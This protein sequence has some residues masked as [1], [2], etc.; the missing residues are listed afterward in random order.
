MQAFVTGGTGFIGSALITELREQ[1]HEVTA[2]VRRPEGAEQMRSLGARPEFIGI[3]D[4]RRLAQAM[5]RCDVV[6]HLAAR[7]QWGLQRGEADAMVSFNVGST[8]AVAAAAQQA[9]VPRFVFT[10]S[11]ASIGEAKGT[12]GCEDS[13]Y[14]GWYMSA[15]E[16]S[17][18][19][20]ER[21][22]QRLTGID[23]VIVN[24]SSVQGP[25]RVAGTG[26]I[27]LAI[28]NG[29]LPVFVDTRFSICHITD[30]VRGHI[31]AAEHGKPGERYILSGATV[32]TSE[33]FGQLSEITGLQLKPRYVPHWL[34]MA[35]AT[36]AERIAW[37]QGKAPSWSR[38]KMRAILHGHRFDGSKATRE[39]GLE[40]TPLGTALWETVRWYHQH[41]HVR[42]SLP[43]FD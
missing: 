39:L 42:R 6:F 11:A 18:R 13:I 34:A 35:G 8:M 1:G 4:V 31:L 22:L 25:G 36:V 28:I 17:K 32:T 15:Y 9:G 30:C 23:V 16:V 37:W 33:I 19:S 3:H 14:R 20:A 5:A 43:R 7:N 29:S 10:S 12:V 38:E 2:I 21:A 24:P 27:M 41:G 26:K 40:Y